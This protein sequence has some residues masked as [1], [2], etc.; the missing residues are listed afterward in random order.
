[1]KRLYDKIPL[2]ICCTVIIF[3]M[4]DKTIP[5]V[6]LLSA[7]SFSSVAQTFDNKTPAFISQLAYISFCI[8]R[9][10]FWC[11]FPVILYDIMYSRKRFIL[12]CISGAAFAISIKS[13][14]ISNSNLLMLIGISAF[15]VLLQIRTSELEK[16][17]EKLISTRDSSAEINMTLSDKN[18]QILD[19]QDYEI[20]LATLKERNRIAREIHDNVGHLLSRSIL[21]VGALGFIN[22][23]KMR[24][25][26]LDSL[27]DTLNNAMTTI[28]NSVHDL[29]NDSIDLKQSLDEIINTLKDNNFTVYSDFEYPSNMPNNEKLCI[30]GI[31]KEAVS[32]IVKH[33]NGNKVV[34]NLI[35]HPA[36]RQLK[37]HDNGDCSMLVAD[38]SGIGLM[39][40]RDRV[41]KLGGLFTFSYDKDGFRIL[42]SLKKE[43]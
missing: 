24:K 35:D 15:A 13:F 39:N 5:V 42:V 11:F 28:R 23:D 21:Q 18:Q 16:L 37:I 19:N 10:E 4:S 22:D 7:I 29:H 32:N 27:S 25:E 8:L 17:T 26:S 31:V 30:I 3:S 6:V 40:M 12:N 41:E 14:E 9:N 34:I 33:S 38:N 20:H 1:M 36:F 2:I 43:V